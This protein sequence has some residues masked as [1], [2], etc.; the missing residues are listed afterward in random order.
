MGGHVKVTFAIQVPSN[1]IIPMTGMLKTILVSESRDGALYFHS[2]ITTDNAIPKAGHIAGILVKGMRHNLVDKS[3]EL[4][5]TKWSELSPTS[6]CSVARNLIRIDPV[7]PEPVIL[8]NEL[9][10][11]A[12]RNMYNYLHL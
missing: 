1:V 10:S 11:G 9:T 8:P 6:A 5:T 4:H 2:K 7:V 12:L 3:K